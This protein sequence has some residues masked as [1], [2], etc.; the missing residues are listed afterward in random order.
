MRAE[1]ERPT[2]TLIENKQITEGQHYDFKRELEIDKR[3][4][5]GSK[6]AK[7]R[8][9]D[10]VVAFLNSG[11]GFLIFG[12]DEKDGAWTA[13]RPI[14]VP[15][16]PLKTRIL[17]TIIDNVDP[18]PKVDVEFIEV[19]GGYIFYVVIPQQGMQPYANKIS[20]SYYQRVGSR[21]RP[22]S[23]GDVQARFNSIEDMERDVSKRF[24]QDALQWQLD[25]SRVAL[26]ES[27]KLSGWAKRGHS[28]L[29]VGIL[30]R[31]HYDRQTVPYDPLR[32]SGLAAPSF[33]GTGLPPMRAGRDG[34]EA[35]QSTAGMVIERLFVST[36]WYVSGLVLE[37]IEIDRFGR[38]ALAEFQNRMKGYF[39]SLGGF[40]NEY[41]IVGPFCLHMELTGLDR[42]S[43]VGRFFVQTDSISNSRPILVESLDQEEFVSEFCRRVNSAA[44]R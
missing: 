18:A 42:S 33:D 38:I 9:I 8:L 43:A 24:E 25:D 32:R 23:R 35:S 36:N 2:R 22:I 34:F 37:P 39:R 31:Q 1:I 40:F 26:S 30:P 3:F 7:V 17:N 21:N 16:D 41:S 15:R 28:R 6:D 4:A 12:V 44:S 11:P 27:Y 20:G 10:D 19:D 13:Y 5:D 14:N 29:Q